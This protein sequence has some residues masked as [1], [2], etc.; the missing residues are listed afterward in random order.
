MKPVS[1]AALERPSSGGSNASSPRGGSP[2]SASTFSTPIV[3]EAL[4]DRRE[5]LAGL[6]DAERWA[7]TSIPY[8]F[9]ILS[10]TSTVP[11]RVAPPAPYVTET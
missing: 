10:A 9:W 11:S 7:M 8:S 6:A 5:A 3:G 2:R 1:S 4:E